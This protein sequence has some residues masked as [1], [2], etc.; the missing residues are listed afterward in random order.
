VHFE[1][2]GVEEH[3]AATARIDADD[4]PFVAA[5]HEDRTVGRAHQ[6]PQEGGAR[7]VYGGHGR[8]E[9]QSAVGVNREVLHLA[10][11][12]LRF[13][14]NLPEGRQRRLDADAGRGAREQRDE[15]APLR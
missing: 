12:E 10:F 9:G 7:L 2:L 15:G 1:L 14:R 11:Q 8:S 6:R 13:R 5:A 4:L 3:A